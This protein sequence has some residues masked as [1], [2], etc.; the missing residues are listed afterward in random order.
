MENKLLEAGKHRRDFESTFKT[1]L[2][3]YFQQPWAGFDIVKFDDFMTK[4]H[5]YDVKKHGSLGDFISKKFGTEAD[6]I[7]RS[8]IKI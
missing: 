2:I 1:K 4:E 7:I 8:L 3:D 5:G 6:L